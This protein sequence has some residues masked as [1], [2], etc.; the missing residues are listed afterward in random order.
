MS[1]DLLTIN[2]TICD[3]P[4]RLKIK[5]AEEEY[6]RKAAKMINTKVKEL[7]GQYQ[8]TDK[9]DYLAMAALMQEVE[10]L[11]GQSQFTLRDEALAG[12]I[13]NLDGKLDE[14]LKTT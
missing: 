6:V 2:L 12:R 14:I 3:R 5:P 8:A 9:Q 13:N 10:N 4:Y 1:E 11:S 7:Q